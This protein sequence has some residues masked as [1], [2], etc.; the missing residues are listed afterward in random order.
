MGKLYNLFKLIE[1]WFSNIKDKDNI[2]IFLFC[3][4]FSIINLSVNSWINKYKFIIII[5]II[6]ILNEKLNISLEARE[7]T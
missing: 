1:F 5:I 7:V 4:R 2:C 3:Q 6:I